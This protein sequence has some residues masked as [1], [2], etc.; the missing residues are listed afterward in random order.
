M[1]ISFPV[2]SPPQQAAPRR[3]SVDGLAE[4]ML[5]L[6]QART[7]RSQFRE[8][9]ALQKQQ[10]ERAAT[11][12]GE[13]IKLS[14]EEAARQKAE[15]DR[16]ARQDE[17]DDIIGNAIPGVLTLN[18]G[19]PTLQDFENLRAEQIAKYP[20]LAGELNNAYNKQ[21][22]E[23]QT[24]AKNTLDRS[25]AEVQLDVETN[26]KDA[27]ITSAKNDAERS[28]V[29][30]VN[31]RLDQQ[32]KRADVAGMPR[33]L[34]AVTAWRESGGKPWKQFAKQFQ[35]P[36]F[37]GGLKP[38]DVHTPPASAGDQ[39]GEEAEQLT[40]V[41]IAAL[42]KYNKVGLSPVAF[43]V[44]A[45]KGALSGPVISR[46]ALAGLSEAQQ[47]QVSLYA[48]LAWNMQQKMKGVATEGDAI[49]MLNALVTNEADPDRVK[50]QKALLRNASVFLT[51]ARRGNFTAALLKFE[52]T[53][54]TLGVTD[55]ALLDPF[56]A[57]R[58]KVKRADADAKN[59]VVRDVDDDIINETSRLRFGRP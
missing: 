22:G 7:Q 27:R 15:A 38:D 16:I 8:Q 44:L 58:P 20:K 19:K 59:N 21:V 30:L 51:E 45:G 37:R 32:I 4:L 39:A 52:E 2:G 46:V 35:V 31:S 18:G 48:P 41:S 36:V 6:T 24:A 54:K 29:E 25:R 17:A 11:E 9:M 53:A 1:G 33:M 49:R 10:E 43:G 12:S 23:L 34:A 47:D 56:I 40:A 5:A 26:T 42:N 28:G 14:K 55:K 13:R 57:L 3:S 50:A